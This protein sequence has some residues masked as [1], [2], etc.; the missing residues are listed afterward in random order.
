MGRW[1]DAAILRPNAAQR[2]AWMSDPHYSVFA[3]MKQFAYTF[4][5]VIMKRAW[6]EA[7][8]HK[9]FGPMGVLLATF[10]P[11]MIAADAAKSLLL[12]KQDPVWMKQGLDTEL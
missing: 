5:D 12:A 10:T 7:K 8:A 3:H 4:H 1:V 6:I 11:M 9:N 2:T